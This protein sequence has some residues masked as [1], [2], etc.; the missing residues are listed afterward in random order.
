VKVSGG[1]SEIATRQ[2]TRKRRHFCRKS[3]RIER[4][5]GHARFGMANRRRASSA[6]VAFAVR[7]Q[8]LASPRLRHRAR[9]HQNL[10]IRMR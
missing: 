5:H 4:S 9:A 6:D 8:L 1:M 3:P 10:V 7:R 2:R